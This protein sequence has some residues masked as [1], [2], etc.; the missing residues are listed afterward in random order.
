MRLIVLCTVTASVLG[1][2]CVSHSLPPVP[3]PPSTVS[4]QPLVIRD[5]LGD[6]EAVCVL[7]N[8]LND[9]RLVCMSVGELRWVI[10]SRGLLQREARR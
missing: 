1:A 9:P 7:R 4:L 8:P 5:T 6:D 10:R 3:E 2:S